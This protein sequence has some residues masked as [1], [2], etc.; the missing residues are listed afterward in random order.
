MDIQRQ[1]EPCQ[2]GKANR[3]Q[4]AFLSITIEVLTR[5]LCKKPLF[6]LKVLKNGRFLSQDREI[7]SL[8]Q[9]LIFDI[10]GGQNLQ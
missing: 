9:G 10:D 6:D 7:I 5:N 2:P 1:K 4:L 8:A 3:T